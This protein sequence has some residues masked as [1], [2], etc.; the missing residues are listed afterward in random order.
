VGCILGGANVWDGSNFY[1]LPGNAVGI[2]ESSQVL[3]LETTAA[4]FGLREAVRFRLR[5]KSLTT[6]TTASEYYSH[7]DRQRRSKQWHGAV[8]FSAT[9]LAS[10]SN[11]N[12]AEYQHQRQQFTGTD[13]GAS[14]VNYGGINAQG[15]MAGTGTAS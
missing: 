2:N 6:S 3:C 9:E 10:G 4:V 1:P 7:D 14:G 5:L 15:V 11:Y 13:D 12:I 8:S